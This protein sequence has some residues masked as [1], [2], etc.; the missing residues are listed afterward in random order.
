MPLGAIVA[1]EE[2]RDWPSGSHAS[3]YGGNPVSC[4]A[5]LATLDL[6]QRE[7]LAN[8]SARGEQLRQGLLGLQRQCPRLGDVRGLGL[9]VAM[10]LVRDQKHPDPAFRDHIVQE[11][12]QRGLLLLGCGESAI[13]FCPPLCINAAQV[14]TAVGILGTILTGST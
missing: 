3:T 7:Y 8:A 1:R 4:R 14:D 6:L 5:A 13:R 9:M 2:V 12:F 10:D 11:A